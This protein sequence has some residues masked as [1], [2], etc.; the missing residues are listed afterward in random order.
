MKRMTGHILQTL[1][2]NNIDC[3]HVGGSQDSYWLRHGLTDQQ[4]HEV[5]FKLCVEHNLKPQ[6]TEWFPGN[7]CS[8]TE[9][10]D[11]SSESFGYYVSP[12]DPS[13]YVYDLMDFDEDESDDFDMFISYNEISWI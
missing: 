6:S 11:K 9:P 2:D 1:R 5:M 4:F 3:T 7:P 8:P 13:E 10:N 12:V